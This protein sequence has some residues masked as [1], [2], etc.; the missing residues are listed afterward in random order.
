MICKPLKSVFINTSHCTPINSNSQT[1][2]VKLLNCN[3]CA[4]LF[5][6]YYR[7]FVSSHLFLWCLLQYCEDNT[8]LFQI[9]FFYDPT[10]RCS[11]QAPNNTTIK[12]MK[13]SLLITLF[14]TTLFFSDYA[15]SLA[16]NGNSQ[17][18]DEYA[19]LFSCTD[20]MLINIPQYKML[21]LDT[22]SQTD[23]GKCM[24]WPILGSFR[25]PFIS[26]HK[27]MG[28]KCKTFQFV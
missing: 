19:T 13:T 9:N 18:L 14:D 20:M 7:S 3:N 24:T 11:T 10:A 2:I 8:A 6:G 12:I 22:Q 21:S 4:I 17:S 28:K 26:H 25:N 1:V 5:L 23:S 16:L 15:M 27:V